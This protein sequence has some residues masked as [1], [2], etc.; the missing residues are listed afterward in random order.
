MARLEL[1]EHLTAVFTQVDGDG[2]VTEAALACSCLYCCP[3]LILLKLFQKKLFT[4]GHLGLNNK[5]LL[6]GKVF[7]KKFKKKQKENG[8]PFF[9]SVHCG[10]M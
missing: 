4:R 5:T 1:A 7:K 9:R 8:F 10:Q 3:T 6:Q 2:L